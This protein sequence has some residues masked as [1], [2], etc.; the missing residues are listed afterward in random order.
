MNR[1]GIETVILMPGI[2]PDGT[3]HFA[4]AAYP[5]DEEVV[6][7]YDRFKDDYDKIGDGLRALLRGAD[8]PVQGVA[9]E[10]AR[11]LELPKGE[12]PMRAIIDYSDYGTEAVNPVTEAQTARVFDIMGYKHLLEAS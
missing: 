11:V 3:A 6:A 10:I 8:A 9:D 5:A 1:F 7:G 2:F 12:K 4:S